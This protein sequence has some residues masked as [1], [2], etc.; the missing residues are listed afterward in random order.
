MLQRGH[1][2][3]RSILRSCPTGW[4]ELV[5]VSAGLLAIL[6]AVF[7]RVVLLQEV[8]TPADMIY[9]HDPLWRNVAPPGFKFPSNPLLSDQVF[10]FYPW[11]MFGSES[12]RQGIVPLWNPYVLAG[13]PFLANQ[14]SAVLYPLNLLLYFLPTPVG[15]GYL[16]IVR[17]LLGG[18]GAYYYVRLLGAGRTGGFVGACAF[19]FGGF[20]IVWL[21][22]PI[23]NVAMLLP[24]T[25]LATERLLRFGGAL[26]F[27]A[28]AMVAGAQFLGGHPETSFHIGVVWTAYLLFRLL[29]KPKS[30]DWRR[31]S[32]RR[33]LAAGASF[34]IGFAISSVQVL[35][36][37][38]ILRE[39]ST[40]A[41]RQAGRGENL[42][43]SV[44]AWKQV[45]SGLSIVSP[46]AFGNPSVPHAEWWN[47]FSNFNEQAAYVGTVPL[48][49]AV[50]G[51]TTWRR[52]PLAAFWLGAGLVAAAIALRLPG[53]EI[54]NHLPIFSLAANARLRLALTF[55]VAVLCALGTDYLLKRA[56]DER[57]V[58]RVQGLLAVSTL[59]GLIGTLAVF[60]TLVILK[61]PILAFGR[62]YIAAQIGSSPGFREPFDYYFAKLPQ[63]YETLTMFYSPLTLRVYLP[64]IWA[65]GLWLLLATRKSARGEA[66]RMGIVL[67]TAADL[68]TLALGY[69]PS[70]PLEQVFPT[71]EAITFLKDKVGTQRIAGVGF[72]LTPNASML[73]RLQDIRG[74]EMT[75]DRQFQ[76]FY[77]SFATR[78]AFGGYQLLAKPSPKLF[79]LLG[80]RYVVAGAGGVDSASG[81]SR[82]F[83]A[84]GVEIYENPNALPRAFVVGRGRSVPDEKA[85]VQT[86]GSPNFRP[87]EDVLLDG[88][89]PTFASVEAR[90]N[91]GVRDVNANEVEVFVST[92]AASW[93]VLSDGYDAGWKAFVDGQETKVYRA[94]YVMRAVRVEAGEHQVRFEYD[95]PAFALGLQISVAALIV[96]AVIALCPVMARA[97]RRARAGT[98]CRCDHH[99]GW[100]PRGRASSGRQDSGSLHDSDG[101]QSGF[102]GGTGR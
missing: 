13:T 77:E 29:A 66:L 35:P 79:E 82:V 99:C 56:D 90:G 7:W 40:F 23:S 81:L 60:G 24:L 80:V 88:T 10:Q 12:L 62:Q 65:V 20:S 3:R 25:L 41:T 59:V 18:L 34:V 22:S 96:T 78:V 54:F 100:R 17:L 70:L 73:W 69:N 57:F 37:L 42:L 43:F 71:T 58:K 14:Q 47:A 28:L 55:C 75:V 89:A 8:L 45:T 48:V 84:D 21:G 102:P 5:V 61:E 39:T 27:A 19:A 72:A 46:N 4:R 6:I 101:R 86:I 98:T 91:A 11:L 53:F 33:G 97:F 52:N 64:I 95:P 63:L 87:R 30:A 93:L 16:A 15:I 68:G 83:A 49:L 9:S 1:S 85:T 94:N 32:W 2:F 51:A 26:N 92:N 31:T 44:D 67:L 74:Y 38:A 76:T 50:I 36:F